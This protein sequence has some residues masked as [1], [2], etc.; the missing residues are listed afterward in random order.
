MCAQNLHLL[1]SHTGLYR[2]LEKEII[3]RT[4]IILLVVCL[5]TAGCGVSKEVVAVKDTE[6][7]TLSGS[8]DNCLTA[9]KQCEADLKATR[10]RLEET[11]AGLAQS[12]ETS[13][14]VDNELQACL[15]REKTI[16]ADLAACEKARDQN[17]DKLAVVQAELA[18]ARDELEQTHAASKT[19]QQEVDS[20]KRREEQ[21][22]EG[23][24]K[25]IGDKNV[26]IEQLLGKLTVRVLDKILFDSGSAAIKPEGKEVLEKLGSVLADHEENIR[27]EGH[28]DNVGISETLRNKY[29]TNWEL[30]G[31]RAASVVTFFETATGIDP[32]RL[33]AVGE[34]F[35]HPVADNE[36]AEGRQKNRRVEIVL[37]SPTK[38]Q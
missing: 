35:H 1:W 24:E 31:A 32:V 7:Q 11:E 6:I 22:R 21:L 3:M 15:D 20:M 2:P 37:T 34:S 26:E 25:E 4:W 27:V 13:I 5:F 33:E 9:R 29:P 16:G 36:D 14:A 12:K 10:T 30:S 17:A 38:R 18:A 28:T 19:A 23:L 8:L